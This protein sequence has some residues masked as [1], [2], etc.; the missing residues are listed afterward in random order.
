MLN[1]IYKAYKTAFAYQVLYDSRMYN[2]K[3]AKSETIHSIFHNKT[4]SKT[5][6][7]L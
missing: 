7:R 4:K 5:I 1:K 2:Y 3:N 6:H